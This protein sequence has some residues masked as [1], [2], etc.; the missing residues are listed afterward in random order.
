MI[1]QSKPRLRSP[2]ERGSPP[3]GTHTVD[4][5]GGRLW[6]QDYAGLDGDA[7]W[8]IYDAG[9]ERVGRIALPADFRPFDIGE[10]WIPRRVTDEIEVEHVR[11][12]GLRTPG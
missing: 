6:V 11:L 8:T 3:Y 4:R 7:P 5:G 12:Y 2:P 9:G 10:D 1:A